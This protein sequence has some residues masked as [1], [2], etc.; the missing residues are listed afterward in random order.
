MK[1][2]VQRLREIINEELVREQQ[3]PPDRTG[4]S[5]GGWEGPSDPRAGSDLEAFPETEPER[6]G[7]LIAS[8]MEASS[9]A[10]LEVELGEAGLQA[11]DRYLAEV[12]EDILKIAMIMRAYALGLHG[13]PE[14]VVSIPGSEGDGPWVRGGG[15]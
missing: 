9:R 11:Y 8:A 2:S 3:F 6:L 15:Q 10:V 13:E 1:I 12:D 14:G 5:V 7:D 4:L